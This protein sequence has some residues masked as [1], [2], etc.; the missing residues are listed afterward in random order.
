M[1]SN[2]RDR[3]WETIVKN[4]TVSE[5]FLTNNLRGTFAP[6]FDAK[7]FS[8]AEEASKEASAPTCW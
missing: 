3:P 8:L 1:G 6:S 7:K 2:C 4:Q 5:P